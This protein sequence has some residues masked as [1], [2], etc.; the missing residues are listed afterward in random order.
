[1]V[2][3]T[4]RQFRR[5]Q[6]T[7]GSTLWGCYVNNEPVKGELDGG[8]LLVPLPRGANRN[9]AFGVD[10]KYEEKID[11]LKAWLFPRT[12]ELTAPKTDVSNTYAEWQLFVPPA[13]R[14][15]GFGGNMTVAREN[16]PYTLREAWNIFVDCYAA[17][18]RESGRTIATI[19]IVAV[20]LAGVVGAAV[21][22]GK[23]GVL[24]VLAVFAILAILAGMMLP[25]LSKAKARSSRIAA[26][27]NLKQIGLAAHIFASEHGERFPNNFEEMKN[28]LGGERV[29]IDPETGMQMVYVGAGKRTDDPRAILAYSPNGR[30]ICLADGSVLQTSSEQFAEALRRD[31]AIANSITIA[32]VAEMQKN[33]VR[34]QQAVTMSGYADRGRRAGTVDPAT[35]LPPPAAG[36]APAAAPMNV[37]GPAIT[38]L[39]EPAK[40][41]EKDDLK[42]QDRLLVQ[43]EAQPVVDGKTTSLETSPQKAEGGL[44]LGAFGLIGG[45]GGM[46]PLTPA[47]ALAPTA[48]GLRSIRIDIPHTGQL[49]KFTKVL[50]VSDAPLAVKMSAMKR[51]WFKAERATIQI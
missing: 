12:I 10:I 47:S 38:P 19:V 15:S 32:Q 31:A 21:R 3:N 41:A 50:H 2:N 22:S 49:F 27:S 20:L 46:A 48:S 13:Q 36:P 28:E 4:V 7:Q 45:G 33:A 37:S 18:L 17:I 40:A 43:D 11:A 26:V 5:F 42:T 34:Q 25:A 51:K 30:A 24:T 23:R 35:G 14:L 39:M 1:M 9:E 16:E 6:L 8:W 44:A 29:L